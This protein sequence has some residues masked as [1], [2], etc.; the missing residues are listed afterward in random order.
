MGQ[1]AC[2][3]QS[4]TDSTE[5]FSS[6]RQKPRMAR[7]ATSVTSVRYARPTKTPAPS[8]TSTKFTSV[9][10]WSIWQT[11]NGFVA[12]MYPGR[13]FSRNKCFGLAERFLAIVSAENNSGI[14]RA[15]VTYDG[16][17]R[18]ASS[19]RA[20][21]SATT[22]ANGGA[23]RV[24]HCSCKVLATIASTSAEIR[25]RRGP[26]VRGRSAVTVLSVRYRAKRLYICRDDSLNSA[27]ARS[28]ADLREPYPSR[29]RSSWSASL[30]AAAQSA[31]VDSRAGV[32]RQY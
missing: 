6:D 3:R 2:A 25:F 20:R 12:W 11:S 14:L 27:A 8:M 23:S 10:V 1:I 13:G 15:T 22:G 19:Q 21:I 18:P 28:M 9:G 24:S 5:G 30:R 7:V 31:S 16:W 17:D 29:M 4:A 32:D 26:D